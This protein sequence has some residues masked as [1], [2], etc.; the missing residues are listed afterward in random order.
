MTKI[1]LSSLCEMLKRFPES[2]PLPNPCDIGPKT[3]ES[4]K[5]KCQPRDTESL[6]PIEQM[7]AR[8]TGIT[9]HKRDDIPDDGLI[10]PCTCGDPRKLRD[11]IPCSHPGC[12]SHITHPCEGCGR[13]AG[14]YPQ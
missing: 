11:G 2:D 4:L 6:T 7:A 14:R 5:A 1:T 9:F 13:I 10:H 12:L 3:Y 8:F